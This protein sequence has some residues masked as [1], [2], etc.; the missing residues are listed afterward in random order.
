MGVELEMFEVQEEKAEYY[1]YPTEFGYNGLVTQTSLKINGPCENHTYP[2]QFRNVEK[3]TAEIGI[4]IQS[5][6]LCFLKLQII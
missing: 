6:V 1:P 4:K 5:F 3:Y 2:T